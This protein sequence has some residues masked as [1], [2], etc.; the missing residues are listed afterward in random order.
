MV[1]Y[2]LFESDSWKTGS[3]YVEQCHYMSF[4]HTQE[5]R[6]HSSNIPDL[7]CKLC[8]DP[9]GLGFSWVTLHV[10]QLPVPI[11]GAPRFS[12]NV[13]A[14]LP[15]LGALVR[16]TIDPSK[17]WYWIQDVQPRDFSATGGVCFL[18]VFCS[19]TVFCLI[20]FLV[21]KHWQF[22]VEIKHMIL[23]SEV[24]VW[25]GLMEG[26]GKTLRYSGYF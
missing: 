23:I 3:L 1:R 2:G 9:A 17:D 19:R 14:R 20:S 15:V 6:W 24:Y 4:S 18:Y 25:V 5:R 10:L 26:L 21:R 11:L 12:L 13:E 8:T 16:C 7:D 22:L